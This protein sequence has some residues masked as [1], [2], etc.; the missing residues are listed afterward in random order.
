MLALPVLVLLA[1]PPQAPSPEAATLKKSCDKNVA[2][3]CYKLAGWMKRE[4]LE[5]LHEIG[6]DEM[7][8]C[9]AAQGVEVTA[10]GVV[11]VA[12]ESVSKTLI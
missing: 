9:A 7:A 11:P 4:R 2:A 3:D 8:A 12:V 10:A 5:P 1:V 6:A